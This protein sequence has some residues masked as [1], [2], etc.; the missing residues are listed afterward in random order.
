M[1]RLPLAAVLA[2]S[3][4]SGLALSL[5]SGFALA[6]DAAAGQKAFAKC[7]TCHALEAGKNGVGPS[8][9]GVFGRKSGT[10]A[11]F[12][13]SDAMVAKGV[14]WD[15]TSIAAYLADP[16]GYIPGNKMVFPG[17]KKE[18]EVADLIAFLKTAK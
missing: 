14:T 16:K 4:T 11:G 8:L 5:T 7:R 13:Y 2:L 18:S 17:I 6:Q 10:G 3:L 15:E 12:K 1:M 9:A